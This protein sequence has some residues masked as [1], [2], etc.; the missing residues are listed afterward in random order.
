MVNVPYLLDFQHFR[1]DFC[2]KILFIDSFF[3]GQFEHQKH[4]I[5]WS[6]SI[7]GYTTTSSLKCEC[8]HSEPLKFYLAGAWKGAKELGVPKFPS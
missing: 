5:G 1:S 3:F 2:H 6:S 4:S 7:E 8:W